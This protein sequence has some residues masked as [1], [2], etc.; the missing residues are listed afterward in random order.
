MDRGTPH[1]PDFRVILTYLPVVFVFVLVFI[2][3]NLDSTPARL[4][5]D[6]DSPPQQ[7]SKRYLPQ[8]TKQPVA[9]TT[10]FMKCSAEYARFQAKCN[11]VN[12]IKGRFKSQ[13]N[14]HVSSSDTGPLGHNR[15]QLTLTN[16]LFKLRGGCG[17]SLFR[18]A[19]F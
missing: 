17:R 16:S 8:P 1:Q 3:L 18:E 2:L 7:L 12:F 10:S 13:S 6:C 19:P 4:P 9:T 5:C 14:L 15:M 11:Q